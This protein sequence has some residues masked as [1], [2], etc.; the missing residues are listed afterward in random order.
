MAETILLFGIALMIAMQIAIAI[1]AFKQ[2]IRA[3]LM[4][5]TIPL[6]VY[7]FAN[8]AHINPW[9]MRLWYAGIGLLI[10]GGVLA[11]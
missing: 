2:S 1:V 8:R 6:Y 9:L 11:S 3:G 7:V 5:L 4:C 10:V